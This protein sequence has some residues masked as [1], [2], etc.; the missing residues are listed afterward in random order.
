[1]IS[2]FIAAACVAVV[3]VAPAAAQES[4]KAL[5][6]AFVAAVVAEDADALAALYTEDADSYPPDGTFARGRAA[7]AASWA[8]FFGAYDG[9]T[10][11]L[12]PQGD[13]ALG[14][15]AVAAWGLWTMSA[16]P[17]EGGEPVVWRGRY[18]DVSIKTAEGWRYF[19]DHASM[20]A[21]ETE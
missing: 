1:M 2:R 4:A 13:R 12:E 21:P 17:V 9:F 15:N 8:A 7:I 3:A 18:S 20:S 16:T 6:D 11:T 10:L 5:Q 14:E 19:I